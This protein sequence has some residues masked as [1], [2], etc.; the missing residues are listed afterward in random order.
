[1]SAIYW[2]PRATLGNVVAVKLK[3]V[4]IVVYRLNSP[5]LGFVICSKTK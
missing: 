2:W 3:V 5:I 1:L 4:S